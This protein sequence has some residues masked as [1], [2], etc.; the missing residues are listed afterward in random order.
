VCLYRLRACR[1]SFKQLGIIYSSNLHPLFLCCQAI[2]T[3]RQDGTCACISHLTAL[4]DNDIEIRHVSAASASLGL[5]KLL[6]NVEALHNLAEDHM[7]AVEMRRRHGCDE[8]LRTIGVW[9]RV[10]LLMVKGESISSAEY[11]LQARGTRSIGLV[12]KG[13]TV[14]DETKRTALLLTA[15]ER[16]PFLVCFSSKFSSAND[17]VP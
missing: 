3:C 16:R 14:P 8:E 1:V 7:F 4:S 11:F 5:L 15:I 6:D 10:L 2:L 12:Y 9:A 13:P 17:F